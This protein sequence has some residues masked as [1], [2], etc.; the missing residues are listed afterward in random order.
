VFYRNGYEGALF[1]GKDGSL[2]AAGIALVL[3][4]V[5]AL[6]VALESGTLNGGVV[7]K[8]ALVRPGALVAH[9]VPPQRVVVAGA[10]IARVA[11]EENNFESTLTRQKIFFLEAFCDISRILAE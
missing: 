4:R 6:H 8:G 11:S 1:A 2:V 10:V 9:L 3:V 5:L 7:A